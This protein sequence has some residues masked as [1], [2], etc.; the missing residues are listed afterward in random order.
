MAIAAG[1]ADAQT[2]A[3]ASSRSDAQLS[4]THLTAAISDGVT[5]PLPHG[6]DGRGSF[7]VAHHALAL[8]GCSADGCHCSGDE[9]NTKKRLR[10]FHIEVRYD[11][12]S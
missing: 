4:T 5:L 3:Q 1:I 8:L 2:P 6:E 7:E 9:R 10:L 11:A 12:S